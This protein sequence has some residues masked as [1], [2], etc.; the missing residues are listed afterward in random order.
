MRLFALSKT[1]KIAK[2]AGSPK[3]INP[4]VDGTA[5]IQTKQYPLEAIAVIC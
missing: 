3:I 1:G 4:A 2:N 5:S